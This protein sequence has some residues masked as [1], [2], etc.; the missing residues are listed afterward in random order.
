MDIRM[1]SLD[2]TVQ[3]L[4]ESC[5]LLDRGN[6]QTDLSDLRC[7]GAGRNDLCPCVGEG[8]CNNEQVGLVINRHQRTPD[9]PPAR[10]IP[11]RRI[12]HVQSTF[13]SA[14]RQLRVA[15]WWVMATSISRSTTL[16]LSCSVSTVSSSAT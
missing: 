13:L 16:I 15:S 2:S 11:G 12:D 4:R 10:I 8:G 6:R 14:T 1:Q 9:R 5:D 7:S 3:A